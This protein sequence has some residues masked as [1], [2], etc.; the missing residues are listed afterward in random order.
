MNRDDSHNVTYPGVGTKIRHSRLLTK[1]VCGVLFG[2]I[3]YRPLAGQTMPPVTNLQMMSRVIESAVQRSLVQLQTDSIKTVSIAMSADDPVMQFLHTQL[4]QTFRG[5]GWEVFVQA[6]SL[7]Q[8]VEVV[9]HPLEVSIQYPE[10]IHSGLFRTSRIVRKASCNL[11]IE[12][13]LIPQGKVVWTGTL[14][15]QKQDTVSSS[16]INAI[17]QNG[18]IFGHPDRPQSGFLKLFEPLAMLAGV[19]VLGYLFYAIRS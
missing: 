4:V 7:F 3:F 12:A 2:A 6:D 11:F 9:W 8:G 10:R 17:E 19:A 14:S 15:A 5:E 16:K 1:L 18:L 13:V